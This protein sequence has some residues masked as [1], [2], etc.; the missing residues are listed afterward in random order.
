MSELISTRDP[1]QSTVSY[2]DVILQGQAPD[3]GLYVPVSYPCLRKEDLEKLAGWSYGQQFADIKSLFA[4]DLPLSVIGDI[5]YDTYSRENFP[6]A[7][8]GN[9]TPVSHLAGGLYVQNLSLGPTAAF[10]D[11]AL[12]PLAREMNHVLSRR[13]ERLNLLGATS[14][15]TGS[16]AEAPIRGLGALSLFMLSPL[17]GM[18]RFQR[19]QMGILTGEN[20]HNI[21]LNTRF[22][23]CQDIVKQIMQDPEFR[24]LGAVNSINWGRIASQVPYYVSGYLQTIDMADMRIGDPVDFVVPTGNFGNALAGYI[25]RQMGVPIRQLILATNEND[26]LHYLVQRGVYMERSAQITSSPSMD[27]SKASNFER[28]LYDLLEGDAK[29][30]SAFM[31]EFQHTGR[32]CFA[33]FGIS[34]TALKDKGFD[35]GSSSH[36]DRIKAIQWVYNHSGIIIDPHTADAVTVAR[37]KHTD[38]DVPMVA[39]STALPVKF[40]ETIHEALGFVPKRETRFERLEEKG[41]AGFVE[42]EVSTDAVKNYLRAHREQ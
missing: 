31:R 26:V 30:V 41:S 24:D 12:Q 16:A 23:T 38:T 13:G 39:M 4:R 14:G 29:E 21:S 1:S 2:T 7:L 36:S 8:M 22:D 34:P 19:A 3:G 9:I 25:A 6:E 27:I 42:L 18:S 40:E 15:D 32:A 35:S 33:D 11:M 17:E 20:I 10:K 37:Q 5:A 28:L